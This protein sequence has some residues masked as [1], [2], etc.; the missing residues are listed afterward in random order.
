MFKNFWCAI[1]HHRYVK[2]YSGDWKFMRCDKC[3]ITW[4]EPRL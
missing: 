2:H 4:P 1:F 3:K